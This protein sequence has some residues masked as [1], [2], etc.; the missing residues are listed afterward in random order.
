MTTR[1]GMEWSLPPGLAEWFEAH[2]VDPTDRDAVFAWLISVGHED[3]QAFID[4]FGQSKPPTPEPPPPGTPTT[5]TVSPS[6]PVTQAPVKV[7]GQ[8][9]P[10][11]ATLTIVQVPGGQNIFYATYWVFGVRYAYRIGTAADLMAI[12]ATGD[13]E[14][15]FQD[16]LALFDGN[17]DRISQANFDQNYTNV[18]DIDRILGATESI[19]TTIQTQ[20]QALGVQNLADWVAE[21]PRVQAI[22]ATA[23]A[24]GWTPEQTWAEIS[25]TPAFQRR[26]GSVF[27]IVSNALGVN[28]IYTIVTEIN[29]QEQSIRDALLTYRGP[30]TP[31]NVEYIDRLL[32]SGWS[33]GEIIKI[34]EAQFILKQ[35]PGA[36]QNLNEIL[37]YRGSEPMTFGQ[38]AQVMAGL[39][40][41]ELIESVNDALR[42]QALEEQGL[43]ISTA[44]AESLGEGMSLDVLSPQALQQMA[45]SAARNVL[46][47]GLELEAGKFGI[48]RDEIIR[49]AFGEGASAET[50]ELLEKFARER[51]MA[52]EG[53]DAFSAYLGEEGRLQI[54]G[55]EN[56]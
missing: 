26:Y 15:S 47:F 54:Q 48:E 37:I 10:A 4:S 40:P 30:D 20:L 16:A 17:I 8:T 36:W 32:A 2:N 38:L 23:A 24:E 21:A 53:F 45:E 14:L 41:A 22:L 28:D 18:D 50:F 52:A 11:G 43:E 51:A 3:P 49:A 9:I 35:N 13:E 12:F 39:A 7:G 5:P 27:D 55:L 33:D 31:V 34:L 56:I 46:R 44:F 19:A 42:Q 25:K 29:R 1:E 6:N